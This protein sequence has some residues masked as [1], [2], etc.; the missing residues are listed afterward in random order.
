MNS[1]RKHKTISGL[2]PPRE[3]L[4]GTR[5]WALLLKG[6]KFGGQSGQSRVVQPSYWLG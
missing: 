3:R 1:K 4:A 5:N 2:P 6:Q